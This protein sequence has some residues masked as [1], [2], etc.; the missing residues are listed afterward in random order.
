MRTPAAVAAVSSSKTKSSSSEKKKKSSSSSLASRKTESATSRILALEVEKAKVKPVHR[1]KALVVSQR[2]VD[3]EQ[4]NVAIVLA[5]DPLRMLTKAA[6]DDN[7]RISRDAVRMIAE[8]LQAVATRT[9]AHAGSIMDSAGRAL[10]RGDD[11][12]R[13]RAIMG[14]F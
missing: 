4:K 12:T 7:M 6:L 2:R 1:R 10:A 13:A 8:G 3:K 14:R 9:A 5:I 11:V